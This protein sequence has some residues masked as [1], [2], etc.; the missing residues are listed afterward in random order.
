M[1][2]SV[3]M[4][5]RQGSDTPIR[6]S[7]GNQH[8]A[9]LQF[10]EP[11]KG[12][13]WKGGSIALGRALPDTRVA[14][15]LALAVHLADADLSVWGALQ[16]LF[17]ASGENDV[18]GTVDKTAPN[19]KSRGAG[20]GGSPRPESFASDV[21]LQDAVTLDHLALEVDRLHWQRYDLGDVQLSMDRDGERM[22]GTV[23]GRLAEGQWQ[24]N[25]QQVSVEL[26]H[27]RWPEAKPALSSEPA[28]AA[29]DTPSV[30]YVPD[31]F[32]ALDLKVRHLWLGEAELGELV[33]DSEK[34]PG[35]IKLHR[36]S[37]TA[38]GQTLVV[39]GDWKGQRP[40]ASGGEGFSTMTTVQGHLKLDD[41]GQTL[42]RLK[43][44]GQ[45]RDTPT[46]LDFAVSW[47]GA[48]HQW[49]VERLMGNMDM[50]LGKGGLP[51]I[52]PGLG[53]VLGILN[54]GTFWRR[55][56]LDFSDLFGEGLAYDGVVGSFRF[57]HGQALTEGL[58]IDAVAAKILMSG[59]AG[60]LQH[61]LDQTITVIPHTTASL[62]IAG[63][64]AGGPA[65][66]AA[67]FVAQ[68][69][70]G[71]KLD[72]MTASHYSVKGSWQAPHIE[73]MA[74]AP[75]LEW[76]NKAWN[77]IKDLSGLGAPNNNNPR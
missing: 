19:R 14:K 44:P 66:G 17:A 67:I 53:R 6:A 29:P 64:L 33:V 72:S 26:E 9:L 8:H 24:F 69:L 73:K 45:V 56:S 58:L 25:P 30:N 52:E 70:I 41:L 21:R 46:R 1:P 40:K 15:G 7:L 11:L 10:T 18:P 34:R 43:M 77:G 31:S 74:N 54:L 2:L 37:L 13:I 42:D 35:H 32:P 50:A 51:R 59:R 48:P 60:L 55:L 20:R 71:E 62:P 16:G 61:D 57:D 47:L 3:D 4:T 22:S 27:L 23:A 39:E 12:F 65:V 38:P 5:L 76:L 63:A 36:L 49:A 28:A 68:R 75:S